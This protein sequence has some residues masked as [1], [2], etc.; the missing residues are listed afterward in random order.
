MDYA[1]GVLCH[2][3]AEEIIQRHLPLW[4][5]L[6]VPI[7]LFFPANEVSAIKG[8]PI[9]YFG[10]SE[11][12]GTSI[13]ERVGMALSVMAIYHPGANILLIEYDCVPRMFGYDPFVENSLV[14]GLTD[15]HDDS[16]YL[17]AMPPWAVH[18]NILRTL[19]DR[20]LEDYADSEGTY[21]Y[22]DRFIARTCGRAGIP[23]LN[24]PMFASWYPH[25]PL[26]WENKAW[27]H[28]VKSLND[29]SK[30]CP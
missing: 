17:C 24:D 19:T 7:R 29:F 22:A 13:Q 15:N 2:Q 14:C 25:G 6:H 26:V 1:L 9:H 27:V 21:G 4:E 10:R 8:S 16:P 20:L 28:A 30:V 5:K 23:L 3:A 18:N 12:A 11:W